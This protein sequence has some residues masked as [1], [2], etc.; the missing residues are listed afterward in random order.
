MRYLNTSGGRIVETGSRQGR[1]WPTPPGAI[2]FYGIRFLCT[3][4]RQHS[5]PSERQCILDV[6]KL[7]D[8]AC[9][10]GESGQK[11]TCVMLTS[12]LQQNAACP[13]SS[14]TTQEG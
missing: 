13:L 4:K 11:W 6:L 2:D 10:T 14:S 12:A 5:K 3:L 1:E 8:T 9:S 7:G